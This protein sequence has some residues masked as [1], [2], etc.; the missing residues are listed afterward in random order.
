MLFRAFWAD[1]FICDVN[2]MI[3]PHFDLQIQDGR[4]RHNEINEK[5]IISE[6]FV[7]YAQNFNTSFLVCMLESEILSKMTAKVKVNQTGSS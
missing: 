4:H 3:G 6:L 5:S 1:E 2:F 7:Q